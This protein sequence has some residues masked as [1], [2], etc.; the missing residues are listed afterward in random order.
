MKEQE[1]QE[2]GGFTRVQNKKRAAKKSHDPET[3]K[4]VQTQKGY[5]VL[6]EP[7]EVINPIN[8]I[9]SQNHP[10]KPKEVDA[11][12]ISDAKDSPKL[13]QEK[14]PNPKLQLQEE[15]QALKED[16]SNTHEIGEEEM[17]IGY[18]DLVGLETTCSNKV[19]ERIASQ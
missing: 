16:T 19:P 8:L 11:P 18:L 4:K 7:Q 9:N 2:A 1:N 3:F 10:E 6:Q 13:P 14:D 12:N 15:N 5:E 17:E